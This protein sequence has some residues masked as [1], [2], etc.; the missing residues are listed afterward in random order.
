MITSIPS[1]PPTPKVPL[2]VLESPLVPDGSAPGTQASLRP[3]RPLTRRELREAEARQAGV[4]TGVIP[5]A[6]AQPVAWQPGPEASARRPAPQP[7]FDEL[8]G[9][10]GGTPAASAPR[11]NG[12]DAVQAHPTA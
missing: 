11:S 3:E 10:A 4:E 6:S 8:F 9:I 12:R 2:H 5:D 1:R 7:S